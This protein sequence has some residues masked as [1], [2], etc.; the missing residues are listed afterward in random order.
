[1]YGTGASNL[2]W[3]KRMG[4]T[5]AG[6]STSYGGMHWFPLR[7]NSFGIVLCDSFEFLRR[8]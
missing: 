7:K 5:A 3:A 1:M 2:R 4:L 6:E 8:Y